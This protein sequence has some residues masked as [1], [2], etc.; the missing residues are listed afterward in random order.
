MKKILCFGD[1][2]VFGFIAQSGDRYDEK[3]RWSGI[4][5]KLVKNDYEVIEE[6]CNN[7]TCFCDNAAG[8]KQTGYKYL[9]CVLDESYDILILALGINDVQKVYKTNE[10]DIEKGFEKILSI[11]KN[12]AP[13]TK[14]ILISPLE[15]TKNVLCGY[16]SALFDEKSIEKSKNI[17]KIC[18]KVAK[19]N[20]CLFLNL[21]EIKNTS[22]PDGLHYDIETHKKIAYFVFDLLRKI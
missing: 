19:N 7:R 16:F 21:N 4:L 13:K 10:F 9:P 15:L 1:S 3:T 8:I 14:I 12:K 18:K 20:N 2:N 5:K 11:A 6:G 17:A 22:L